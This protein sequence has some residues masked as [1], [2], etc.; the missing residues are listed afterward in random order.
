MP[1]PMAPR[2]ITP[3]T[4]LITSLLQPRSFLKSATS[5][6]GAAP[7]AMKH[8]QGVQTPASQQDPEWTTYLYGHH[9][10]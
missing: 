8:A 1:L 2:P 6:H 7:A 9:T 4:K 5:I 10:T 3:A